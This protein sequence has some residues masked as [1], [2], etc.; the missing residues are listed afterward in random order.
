MRGILEIGTNLELVPPPTLNGQFLSSIDTDPGERIL[1]NIY[2]ED[3][4]VAS[5]LEPDVSSTPRYGMPS[6]L[7]TRCDIYSGAR[8]DIY[9]GNELDSKYRTTYIFCFARQKRRFSHILK[10]GALGKLLI[11]R[12][13]EALSSLRKQYCQ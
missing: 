13:S 8:C 9:Y 12:I 2:S 3:R 5:L 1:L 11:K 10:R 7:A 6:I 4:G